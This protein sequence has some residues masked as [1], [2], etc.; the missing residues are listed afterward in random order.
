MVNSTK[1]DTKFDPKINM[2]VVNKLWINSP[3]SNWQLF[4]RPN[5]FAIT[6]NP[7][8]QYN[9]KIKKFFTDRFLGKTSE[10]YLQYTSNQH[11]ILVNPDCFSP[12][13]TSCSCS[14]YL[15]DAMCYHLLSCSLVDKIEYLGL[16]AKKFVHKKTS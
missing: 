5:G 12:E 6:N 4:N 2:V 14:F 3:F 13:C 9:G 1:E 8:E 11:N 7:I 16:F 15:H 10:E